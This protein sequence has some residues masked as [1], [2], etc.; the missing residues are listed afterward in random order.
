MI[1]TNVAVVVSLATFLAGVI[2]GLVIEMKVS[3]PFIEEL[4]KKNKV[5]KLKLRAEQM[6]HSLDRRQT[7]EFIEIV[8][9]ADLYEE[10]Y[11]KPF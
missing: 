1:S 2:I 7:P 10:D 6:E 3:E 11:F 9:P 5:L 4:E 8:S